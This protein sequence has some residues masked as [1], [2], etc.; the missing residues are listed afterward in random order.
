M[1][2]V[3]SGS[4]SLTAMHCTKN[5]EILYEKLHFLR[6]D[7]QS[8]QLIIG[9]I[10]EIKNLKDTFDITTVI[11]KLLKYSPK[12]EILFKTLKEELAP[13]TPGFRALC[14]A[15]WTVRAASLQSV[16]GNQ[17]VLQEL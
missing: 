9:D 16:F 1:S 4:F 14:P 8:L 15:R 11:S 6:A 12:K 17:K 2:G 7:G 13:G 5:E 10:K 3:K